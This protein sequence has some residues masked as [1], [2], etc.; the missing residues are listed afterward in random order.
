MAMATD[1]KIRAAVERKVA[2]GQGRLRQR[3]TLTRGAI[4]AYD[5]LLLALLLFL[6][7][8]YVKNPNSFSFSVDVYNLAIESM[9]FGSLGGVIISLKGIYDHAGGSD[10]WD[11]S[12]NLWHLGRP[13]SGAIAGLVTV[14]LLKVV[15]NGD[16]VRPVVFAAAFIFGTQE[17]RFFN[18]L[19]EI[20]RLIV[21]VPQENSSAP[22]VADDQLSGPAPGA[23][24]AIDFVAQNTDGSLCTDRNWLNSV[25]NPILA[26]QMGIPQ[27]KLDASQ[28]FAYYKIGFPQ[29]VQLC[30]D[31]TGPIN[32][33]LQS[34]SC[35]QRLVLSPDWISQHKDDLIGPFVVAV[36]DQILKPA[37]VVVAQ[38]P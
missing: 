17:R 23:L 3:R 2:D 10:P 19:Y 29:F 16:L 8:W 6:G 5:L 22:S 25:V 28:N 21:Q 4:F 24:A 30:R 33:K 27:S 32:T 13:A 37:A 26:Q 7:W 9:W 12:Y 31:I 11:P 35:K 20:A 18:F 1:E 34:Q 14:V 36:V 38:Q 15:N